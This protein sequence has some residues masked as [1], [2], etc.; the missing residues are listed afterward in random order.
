MSTK[1]L[2]DREQVHND[3][4][5][6]GSRRAEVVSTMWDVTTAPYVL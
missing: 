6:C 1:A 3:A 5:G 4:A 2:K